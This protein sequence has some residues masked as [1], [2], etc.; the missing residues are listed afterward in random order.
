M[1][2]PIVPEFVSQVKNIN[3]LWERRALKRKNWT[4]RGRCSGVWQYSQGSK[5]TKKWQALTVTLIGQ[6][7]WFSSGTLPRSSSE[8]FLQIGRT[9]RNPTIPS[10]SETKSRRDL[11]R[12]PP[13]KIG[14]PYRSSWSFHFC[15]SGVSR[16]ANCN[17]LRDYFV[18]LYEWIPDAPLRSTARRH[19]PSGFEVTRPPFSWMLGQTLAIPLSMHKSIDGMRSICNLHPCGSRKLRSGRGEEQHTPHR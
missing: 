13:S 2:N 8:R 10:K 4:T 9:A 18:Q 3:Y 19:V 11:R 1:L 12:G 6:I 7:C 16:Y 5:S 14:F 15:F 17:G